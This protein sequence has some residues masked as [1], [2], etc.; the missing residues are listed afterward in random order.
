MFGRNDLSCSISTE[1][2]GERSKL[3]KISV[4]RTFVGLAIVGLFGYNAD[5]ASGQPHQV[6]H[7]SLVVVRLYLSVPICACLDMS[8]HIW[9]VCASLYRFVAK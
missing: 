6:I 1:P 9:I 7:R 8:A 5:L 2:L 3:H 4:N